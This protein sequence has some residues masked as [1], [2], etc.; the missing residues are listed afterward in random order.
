MRVFIC[1]FGLIF[2][3]IW[4]V[5]SATANEDSI[6]FGPDFLSP[7]IYHSDDSIASF[8][9]SLTIILSEA[10]GLEIIPDGSVGNIIFLI[11]GNAVEDRKINLSAFPEL[12][13]AETDFLQRLNITGDTCEAI[14]L[15]QEFAII[16]ADPKKIANPDHVK[17]CIVYSYSILLGAELP[18]PSSEKSNWVDITAELLKSLQRKHGLLR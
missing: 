17:I 1:C 11:K 16:V 2:N 13:K 3:L 6:V 12:S 14:I 7:A 9:S 10:A 15:D 18:R 5:N 4:T 8:I